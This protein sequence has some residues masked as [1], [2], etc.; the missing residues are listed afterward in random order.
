MITRIKELE[1]ILRCCGMGYKWELVHAP[2]YTE[3]WSREELL[4]VK[5]R[6]LQ[7]EKLREAI[8]DCADLWDGPESDRYGDRLDEI[9]DGLGIKDVP[10]FYKKENIDKMIKELR[11]KRNEL[12]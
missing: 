3:P 4:E 12:V 8:I 9:L 7:N 10:E 6:I 11:E 2:A 1:F 5:N